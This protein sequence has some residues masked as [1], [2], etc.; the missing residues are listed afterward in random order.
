VLTPGRTAAFTLASTFATRPAARIVTSSA[1]DLIFI[2][3]PPGNN[4][5]VTCCRSG[6]CSPYGYDFPFSAMV[7][8][9]SHRSFGI[10]MSPLVCRPP[11]SYRKEI[12]IGW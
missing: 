7:N 11:G 9:S 6:V 4:D 1:G 3:R 2:I 8:V 12:G 5:R 10:L